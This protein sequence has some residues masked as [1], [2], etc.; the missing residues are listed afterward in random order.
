M[1]CYKPQWG[2]YSPGPKNPGLDAPCPGECRQLSPAAPTDANPLS[3]ILQ[4]FFP[5][6][7]NGGVAGS[8]LW[9]THEH[10]VPQATTP[11][12][13]SKLSGV[14]PRL[15]VFLLS[16]HLGPEATKSLAR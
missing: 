13:A 10:F 6:E 15:V 4:R 2:G 11:S 1:H 12:W 8:S 7:I 14:P 5:P 9:S 16:P 3:D